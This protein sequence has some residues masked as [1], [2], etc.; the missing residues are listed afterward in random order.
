[1]SRRD[2]SAKRCDP[3]AKTLAGNRGLSPLGPVGLIDGLS[4]KAKDRDRS[5]R[6]TGSIEPDLI[7][8]ECLVDRTHK[9]IEFKGLADIA[10][11]SCFHP[12]RN[13]IG[14][15]IGTESNDR[16]MRR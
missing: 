14:H 16:N 7:D 9:F 10:E 13:I 6:N 1:M 11:K 2:P 5:Q 3:S 12:Y 8:F 15:G 4:P